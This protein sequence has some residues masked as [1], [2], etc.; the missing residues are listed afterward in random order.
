MKSNRMVTRVLWGV[1]ALAMGLPLAAEGANYT[2]TWKSGSSSGYWSDASNNHWYRFDDGWDIRREDLATGQWDTGGTKNYNNIVFANSDQ[3]SMTVNDLGGAQHYIAS[4]FF[5]NSTSRTFAQGGAAFLKLSSDGTPKI[6]A[7]SG[8]GTGTY[9]FNVPLEFAEA[10]ELNPVGGNLTF[11]AAITNGGYWFD[12]YGGLQKTLTIGGVLS[13]TG[14]I[15]NKADN[16]VILTN[17]NTFSGAIWVE[18][19]T[20]KVG[21]HTN[22]IGASGTVNV[23]TNA[24]LELTYG[25]TT[26]RPATLN[27]YGTGTN[28]SMGALRKTT[29][30]ATTWRGAVA[31]GADSKI[32]VTAGGMSIY[33]NVTAGSYTLYVTNKATVQMTSGYITGTKTT[34]DGAIYKTG[35]STLTLRPG[36]GLTGSILLYQGAIRQ[37]VGNSSTVPSGGM[38]VMSNGTTYRTATTTARTMAKASQIR[39]DVT[40]GYSSAHGMTFSGNMDLYGGHRTLTVDGTT[41]ISGAITNGGLT[42]AGTK[43]LTLSGANTYADG[44]L[45]S[46]GTL[47]IGDSGTSGSVSGAITNNSALIFDR[48]D[49]LTHSGIISGTG[50]LT[51]NGS[52]TLTL[53]GANT[54]SG[55]TTVSVGT[56]LVSGSASSSAFTVSS[57]ATLS[58]AG[59]VG[60]ISSLSGTVSPGN[61]ADTAATLTVSGAATLGGGTYTCDI[62]G[63]TSTDC[64][65]IDASGAVSAA[66]TLTIDL[67]TS[68]P[69]G[70]SEYSSYTWTVMSGSSADASNMAIGTKWTASGTFGVS[71]NGNDIEVTYTAA[72]PPTPAGLTASDGSS[73]VHVALSWTDGA[74]ETGYVIWRYTTDTPGSA[75]A[76]DTNAADAVTYN[77]TSAAPGQKYYYWVSA[78]N[79]SGSSAKSTS[80]SGYRKLATV[81]SVSATDGTDLTKVVL[82]WADGTGETGY[83][84]WRNTSD[85]SGSA[86]WLA[87]A[88]ADATSYDDSSATA[89]QQYYYW[90]R[91][92]NSTSASQSDFQ[93]SGEGGYVKLPTVAG[94]SATDTLTDK[95]T[96]SWT[97]SDDGETGYTVWRYTADTSGSAT[98]ING[99]PLAASATS[100][101]DTSAVAGTTYYYWV[102][103]TN[104][105][106]ASMSDFSASDSGLRTLTEPTT[107][108]SAITFSS[109][110]TT[111]YTVGWTRGDGDYVLVV[112]KQGSAPTAPTD[113]TAYNAD[114]AF[115]SGDTTAAGSY[116]VYKGTGTSVP[117]TAMIAG[118]EYY[119]AVYEF[120]GTSSPNYRT[121]DA[122]VDSQHT[123][124]SEPT[125]QASSIAVGT[126]NEVSLASITWTDGNGA[127]RLVVVKAGSAVDSFP[128]DGATYTANATF[129]SGTEIGTG[130]YVVHD[131]A[132][133]LA[134][135]SGLTRDV[136]YH[137][138]VFEYNGTLGTTANF[139]TDSATGNPISQT[140]KAV[141]PGS[142]PTGLDITAIGTNGF[143][144]SWTKG[145]TGTNTLIVVRAG[146][147]PLNPS[148]LNSYTADPVFGS[149]S[150]LGSSSY[151]VYNGTGSSVTVSGLT[152]GT[153]YYVEASSFNGSSGSENYRGTPAADNDYTLDTEPTQSTSITFGT[154]DS[155]SYAVSYTAGDGASRLVILKAGSAVSWTPSDATAY[156][157]E[158]PDIGAAADMGSGNLLVHR[159][160][161]PFTLT[162]LSAATDYYIRIYEYNGA[163]ATLNYNVNT[164]SGNPANRYSLSTEPSAHAAT[165]TA[166]ATSD[167]EI[168]LDWGA[169]TGESGFIIV[170]KTGSA[171]TGTPVD[172]TQYSQGDVIGDGTVVYVTTTSGAGSTTDSYSTSADTAYY[173][174][175]YPYAYDGT[176][177]NET[178]NYRTAATVPSDNATT[179]PS[180][181]GTSS[182]VTSF[183]PATSTSATLIWD[184]A[185][186]ADGSIILIQAGSAVDS[187]PVDWT[188]YIANTV[189]QSGDEIGTGNFVVFA[190]AGKSGSVTITGLGAGTNYYAAVYPYNGSGS[191]L[192]Y[193][194]TSPGTDN[195]T[196]LPAPTAQ[197][198]TA[199]GKTLIDLAWTK[200]ASYDVM[201]VY[202]AGSASTAPTQGASYSVGGACGGGIVIYK[203]SAAALEH[204]VADGTTHYYAFYSYSGTQYSAGVTDSESTTAFAIGEIVET[205]SY[206]N[207]TAMT[208]LDGD[209]GWGGGWYGDTG[210]Y[211]N[212]SGSF[213]TQTNYPATSGN[214]AWV[215]PPN[216]T[217]KS[218]YRPLAQEYKSGKIYFGYILNY[219]YSGANKVKSMGRTSSWVSTA[220]APLIR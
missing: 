68:A 206:T 65:K 182:T 5:S 193:K 73:T 215:Y 2:T 85:A 186:S 53:S 94:V 105:T 166:T 61:T 67:P 9:T 118:T 91:A 44:T 177:A 34:G 13:G 213:T 23:G 212:S 138:R 103:A 161:S 176:P 30:G 192:N 121:S 52:G 133:P 87:N 58:G 21:T 129:G 204:I 209:N 62:T 154:L 51:K 185:G 40:L 71:A 59:T 132:S 128:V 169:A 93:A 175:I 205:F 208:G 56:V 143:T 109:L 219:Q 190:G 207:S 200:N 199:D 178:Y 134:T 88:A 167:T 189:F 126:V 116:V 130:N 165:F 110:D 18:K 159:G 142:N 180:E 184:N 66:S 168:D 112:A 145:T 104:S 70:F 1:L 43:V 78:T 36:S 183:L 194:T 146:A 148:D 26:V 171:P 179:G 147:G 10:V 90:V 141:T 124:T 14:G 46:A 47:Q 210:V 155:T 151:V 16:I 100:Y 97:D 181:P 8:S 49:A 163:S 55:N 50:T 202:K 131:G 135:L 113:F 195:L 82:T 119:F 35:S 3:S 76:I 29:T 115:G 15:A 220:P 81:G 218:I 72:A 174:Q 187:N 84:I 139:L 64:D 150:D 122:P 203:G 188:N 20:V 95:V 164:A 86:T 25:G 63:L 48:S 144:I 42:K 149:G 198:A 37:N 28:S 99:A 12:V 196:I 60:S 77:D 160:S 22:A 136:I 156:A 173:Y 114:A 19:G 6:E 11:N 27:L 89:G 127:G 24:T 98:L 137:F 83:G 217:G 32:V 123:L 117:V 75:T 197:S 107:A 54:Y 108:A 172:G 211:T 33:G 162:G 79:E 101:D 7:A 214:K 41:T 96:V 152:P 31:L 157:G 170:R 45:I 201:I 57:G 17:N 102:R 39:G 153:R 106:S 140:T 158:D 216:D 74:G 111:S 38:L 120:N 4:I 92:T 191:F 69:S 80:D 125:T